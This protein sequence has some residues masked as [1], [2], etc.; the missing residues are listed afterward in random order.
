MALA[1]DEPARRLYLENLAARAQSNES[2]DA[3]RA[4]LTAVP[5]TTQ[6][7]IDEFVNLFQTRVDNERLAAEVQ[8]RSQ[9]LQQI[10][11]AA[12]VNDSVDNV[13]LAL[14]AVVGAT[15]AEID[16][17]VAIFET[18]PR[19]GPLGAP[20]EG[21]GDGQGED[22]LARLRRQNEELRNSVSGL[23]ASLAV[24]AV[25][26]AQIMEQLDHLAADG[27]TPL[28]DS[29]ATLRE[30]ANLFA[31]QR[32]SV[33]R[34]VP[35]HILALAPHLADAGDQSNLSPYLRKTRD[36]ALAVQADSDAKAV[37]YRIRELYS[38]IG[39]PV[40]YWMDVVRDRVIDFSKINGIITHGFVHRDDFR[41]AIDANYI[42]E[43][44]DDQYPRS[45]ITH[46][47]EWTVCYDVWASMVILYYAHRRDELAA[48]KKRITDLFTS[49]SYRPQVIIK[50]DE[51]LRNNY[52]NS[53][54]RLDENNESWML[55][56]NTIYNELDGAARSVNVRKR[57]GS[58]DPGSA[59]KK[60]KEICRLWNL[61]L[62]SADR[63]PNQRIHGKCCECGGDHQANSKTECKDSLE[64]KRSTQAGP[65]RR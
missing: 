41:T 32:G 4:S 38:G 10:V 27:R 28:A 65:R 45:P 20:P 49:L 3:V 6:I 9:Q 57:S 64:R 36:L 63:C 55:L 7:E 22:E 50:L 43:R 11:D 23:E 18:R 24:S 16:A 30:L 58:S 40:K 25:E 47:Y 42:I 56:I 8:R 1:S 51:R 46:P 48:Y 39:M 5:G 31:G 17:F 13:R 2:V 52:G 62:C 14:A 61:G 37:V 59:A 34:N 26:R 60:R 44:V 53:P 12:D 29:S 15:Q 35:A 33:S 54:F 21:G 19:P